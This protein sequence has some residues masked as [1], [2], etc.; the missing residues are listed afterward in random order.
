MKLNSSFS[1]PTKEYQGYLAILLKPAKQHERKKLSLQAEFYRGR[2]FQ[3]TR[4]HIEIIYNQSVPE[5]NPCLIKS[6]P[7]K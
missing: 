4:N 5:N 2:I 7:P 6:P 1:G 3:I